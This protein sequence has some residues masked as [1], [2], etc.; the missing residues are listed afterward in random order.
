MMF[1]IVLAGDVFNARKEVRVTGSLRRF[2]IALRGREANGA[3]SKDAA[4]RGGYLAAAGI[5]GHTPVVGGAERSQR[6]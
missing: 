1:A 2:E 4:M 3:F 5:V 6:V